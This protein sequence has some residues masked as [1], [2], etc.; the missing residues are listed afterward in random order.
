MA[1]AAKAP[2]TA[3]GRW[4]EDEEESVAVVA[5]EAGAVST[6]TAMGV[7]VE[8]GEVAVMGACRR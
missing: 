3:A 4:G 1:A 6:A 5:G 2:T 8:G 7:M